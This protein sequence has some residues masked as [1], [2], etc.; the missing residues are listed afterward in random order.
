MDRQA[1]RLTRRS[2]GL[3]AMIAC[4]ISPDD[5]VSFQT[6]IN[7]FITKSEMSKQNWS[8]QSSRLSLPQ[9]HTMNTLREILINSRFR[10]AIAPYIG[11][12]LTLATK[13]LGSRVW[14]IRN[15]GLMLFRACLLRLSSER[16][17]EAG[18]PS[19]GSSPGASAMAISLLRGGAAY[20]QTSNPVLSTAVSFVQCSD[21]DNALVGVEQGFAALD[22]IANVSPMVGGNHDLRSYLLCLCDGPI[23]LIRQRAAEV[24]AF[25][26]PTKELLVEFDKCLSSM[27]EKIRQNGLHGRL[28]YCRQLLHQWSLRSDIAALVANFEQLYEQ[29]THIRMRLSSNDCAPPV[30]AALHDIENDLLE[31]GLRTENSIKHPPIAYDKPPSSTLTVLQGFYL[32]N[33]SGMYNAGLY[34]LTVREPDISDSE[35]NPIL[36]HRL[37][38]DPDVTRYF[39]EKL[40]GQG[41]AFPPRL[42]WQLGLLPEQMPPDVLSLAIDMVSLSVERFPSDWDSSR[43]WQILELL[44]EPSPTREVTASKMVAQ[45]ALF[46]LYSLQLGQPDVSEIAMS[47]QQLCWRND[48]QTAAQDEMDTFIRLQAAKAI[49]AYLPCLFELGFS[50]EAFALLLTLHGLLNDDDEDVRSSAARTASSFLS[51]QSPSTL[52]AEGLCAPTAAIELENHLRS[53]I[54]KNSVQQEYLLRRLLKADTGLHL[55]VYLRRCPVQKQLSMIGDEAGALFAVER[56]NLYVDEVHEVHF[57]SSLCIEHSGQD[58]D[59]AVGSVQSA[60]GTWV[61]DA[62]KAL[63]VGLDVAEHNPMIPNQT[64]DLDVL[65]LCVRAVDVAGVYLLMQNHLAR[66]GSQRDMITDQLRGLKMLASQ[67]HFHP[68]LKR[69]IDDN[70]EV[71]SG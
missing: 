62:L 32:A 49:S 39:L 26:T 21:S 48:V 18:G 30:M 38:S 4:I 2:A 57:W 17:S 63:L 34:L 44:T 68:K 46:S 64:F 65:L 8:S 11:K 1:D 13:N 12:L 24:L 56:Q 27:N 59:M 14:P 43:I 67:R 37:E 54:S 19:L 71:A 69:S 55:E 45:A 42:L 9:V 58:T 29:L 15:C 33:R 7:T 51:K 31:Q 50:S 25:L 28:L 41:I 52:L 10:V 20:G 6:F 35:S 47:R 22:M 36:R 53:V 70:L 60:L 5:D 40:L 16:D 66:P 61:F 23:W 3:P